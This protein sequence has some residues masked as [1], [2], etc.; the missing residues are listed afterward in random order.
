MKKISALLIISVFC[1]SQELIAADCNKTELT[2]TWNNT[3]IPSSMN[4]DSITFLENGKVDCNGCEITKWEF[5]QAAYPSIKVY[6]SDNTTSKWSC[7]SNVRN[8]IVINGEIFEK[9]KSVD[10]SGPFDL[11]PVIEY[12]DPVTSPNSCEANTEDSSECL[13]AKD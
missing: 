2:G 9:V 10:T 5:K 12:S 7:E 6:H 8:Y 1:I 13:P 4:I 11:P 3:M